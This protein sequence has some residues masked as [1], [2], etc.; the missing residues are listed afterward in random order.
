MTVIERLEL[1]SS[2]TEDLPA[3]AR[4]LLDFAGDFTIFAFYGE[5]GSGKTTFI[6]ALCK[7]LK[8]EDDVCSPTFSLVNEYRTPEGKPVY[9]FDFYR[10]EEES[11]AMDIGLEEYL[12][13]GNYCFM[14]WSEKIPNLLPSDFVGVNIQEHE[15]NRIINAQKIKNG[16]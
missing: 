5:M 9:H 16:I 4:R 7:E 14:E 1:K 10:M 8:V 2:S 3:L 12:Y 6:K 11:E 15:S 13:D